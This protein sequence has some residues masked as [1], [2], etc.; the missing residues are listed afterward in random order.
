MDQVTKIPATQYYVVVDGQSWASF[1]ITDKGDLFINSDWGYW[2]Y[3]WRAFGIDFRAFLADLG[4]DYLIAKLE[5]NQFQMLRAGRKT[6]PQRSQEA[7]TALF[8][9]F[10]AELKKELLTISADGRN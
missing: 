2:A 4:A 5:T 7:I 9:K 1:V 6:M 3:A 10:Q 8:A